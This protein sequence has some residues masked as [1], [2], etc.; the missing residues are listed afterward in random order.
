MFYFFNSG[1]CLL[2]LLFYSRDIHRVRNKICMYVYHARKRRAA[3]A[4]TV[5]IQHMKRGS[6]WNRGF[7]R[8]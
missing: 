2:A 6:L 7:G 5:P 3:A 1:F 8:F 4:A